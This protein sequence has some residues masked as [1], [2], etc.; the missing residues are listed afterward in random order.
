M[1]ASRSSGH[2]G[3]STA[4]GSSPPSP[5]LIIVTLL[6]SAPGIP[7]GDRRPALLGAL[8]Q[9][10]AERVLHERL[11]VGR[12]TEQ[13]ADRHRG[14]AGL[15]Q[16]VVDPVPV[17]R[18]VALHLERRDA[19]HGGP[20][21][22]GTRRTYRE[23]APGARG[24]V[25]RPSPAPQAARMGRV[26]I[27]RRDDVER[28]LDMAACIDAVE[29]AFVAYSAGRAELPGVIHLDV[30]EARGEVH[31]KA[32]HLHGAP[33]YA[34]KVASGFAEPEPPAID[35]MVLVFDA[36][37]GAPLALLLDGGLLTDL[38][39]GAAGGVAA[40]WLAPPTV[41]AGRGARHRD[42]GATAGRGAP[43]RATRRLRRRA[44]GPPRRARGRRRGRGRRGG[45]GEPRCG[46]ARRRRRRHLHRVTRPAGR[47]RLARSAGRS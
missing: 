5:P 2:A 40:R 47:R 1:N 42:P 14:D 19:S 22:A 43:G 4:T 37:D 12:G 33:A 16:V 3:A 34:V 26:R 13:V 9:G 46:G 17:E 45:R 35:G 24:R 6:A 27:L 23:R 36:T 32:G 25:D 30:P 21:G 15:R 41:D 44:V 7:G 11:G 38:R 29:A 10:V 28:A 31:V 20:P 8:R 39:T 18:L